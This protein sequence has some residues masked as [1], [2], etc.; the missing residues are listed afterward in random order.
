MRD[1]YVGSA[2][3]VDSV[4]YEGRKTVVDIDLHRSE[5]A[6][7]VFTSINGRR[8]ATATTG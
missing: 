4:S 2:D 8:A 5:N 1:L 7:D 3:G 6:G